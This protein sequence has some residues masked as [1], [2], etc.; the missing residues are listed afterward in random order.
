MATQNASNWTLSQLV[1]SAE[2]FTFADGRADINETRALIGLIRPFAAQD[3]DLAAFQKLLID[4]E[5]DG[6]V[7]PEESAAL[8]KAIAALRAKYQAS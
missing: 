4:I 2:K 5:E 1:T 8:A 3:P 7:T 6:V